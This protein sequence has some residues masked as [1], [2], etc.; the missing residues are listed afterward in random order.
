MQLHRE[1]TYNSDNRSFD[2]IIRAESARRTLV[3]STSVAVLVPL[4][5]KLAIS[6]AVFANL[7][8]FRG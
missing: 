5:A 7:F 8:S 4:C 1:E 6:S 2:D 3:R